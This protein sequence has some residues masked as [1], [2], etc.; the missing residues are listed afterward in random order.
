M[1]RYSGLFLFMLIL[2]VSNSVKTFECNACFPIGHDH[3][4]VLDSYYVNGEK[5]TLGNL[6]IT[7]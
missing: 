6:I 7:K 5:Q 1:K 4:T 2:V 3:F